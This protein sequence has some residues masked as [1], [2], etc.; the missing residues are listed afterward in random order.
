MQVFEE[1]GVVTSG[2][3]QTEVSC[4]SEFSIQSG[5]VSKR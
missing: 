3:E 2:D 1:D 5:L 4:G